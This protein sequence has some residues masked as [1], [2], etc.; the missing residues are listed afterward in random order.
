[1]V[2]DFILATIY[3]FV[4]YILVFMDFAFSYLHDWQIEMSFVSYV[5]DTLSVVNTF[6]PVPTFL[7]ICANLLTLELAL[8]GVKAIIWSYKKIPGIH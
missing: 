8:W 2:Y 7:I 5:G 3:N 6:F 4:H 1:M